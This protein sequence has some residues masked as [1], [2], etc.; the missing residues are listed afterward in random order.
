[1]KTIELYRKIGS[2]CEHNIVDRDNVFLYTWL[3]VEKKKSLKD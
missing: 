1:M 2:P 3:R